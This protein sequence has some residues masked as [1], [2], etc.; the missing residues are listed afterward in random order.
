MRIVLIC[1]ECLVLVYYLHSGKRGIESLEKIRKTSFK[2]IID[3]GLSGKK[4]F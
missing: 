4:L 2:E 1:V 3:S